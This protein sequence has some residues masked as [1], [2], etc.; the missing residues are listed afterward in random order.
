MNRDE[1]MERLEYLLSDIPQ[2][3]KEDALAYY[4]DYLEEAGENAGEAIEEFG[5]PERVASI[6]R[7]DLA[8]NLE[9]G[10]EFTDRGYDDE[11]FRDPNYQVAKRLDLPE[12]R[13]DVR[14]S[15]KSETGKKDKEGEENKPWSN[16]ILKTVL[17]II[18]LIVA[19][20]MLLGAGGV[21]MGIAA[22]ILGLLVGL[23]ALLG[24][25]TLTM[26]LGGVA[27]CILGIVSMAGWIPGG[28]LV[29][30]AGV[31]VIGLGIL[32][33]LLSISFYGRFLPWLVRCVIDGIGG[34]VHRRRKV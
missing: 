9:E 34:L 3:E 15:D 20:P 16:G 19:A 24:V 7:S 10:G 14:E 21:V 17:W 26:L 27:L 13:E 32:C 31:A 29:L 1:F 5:S 28:L 18:L 6:I 23:I 12:P 22:G 2:E 25:L 33:L 8:G 4:R 30:G 11:R